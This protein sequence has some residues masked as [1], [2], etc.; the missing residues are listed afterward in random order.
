VVSPPR[1]SSLDRLL[2]LALLAIL[3]VSVGRRFPLVA[4]GVL[5]AVAAGRWQLGRARVAAAQTGYQ[6]EYVPPAV[7]RGGEDEF[8]L[9]YHEGGRVTWF[10]GTL[11]GPGQ[12]DQLVLP[13]A[14]A[15]DERVEP[16]A[17]GRRDEILAR[18]RADPLVARRVELI[19]G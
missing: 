13:S 12:R 16:F 9:A 2:L 10:G 11:G 1:T 4:L 17:R 7:L 5:G 14:E 3:V 8:A 18:I 19:E 15:W 6:V